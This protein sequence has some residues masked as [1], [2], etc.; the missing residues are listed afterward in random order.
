MTRIQKLAAALP[1]GCGGA[2]I[3]TPVNR[4]YFT[5]FSSSDGVLFVSPKGA[6]F[7][8]DSRYIE[9]ARAASRDPL[10]QGV[11]IEEFTGTKNLL[12]LL[13]SYGAA[14]VLLE[15]EITV[16]TWQSYK[17]AL[18]GVEVIASSELSS[19]ISGMRCIKEAG[20]IERMA[21]AAAIADLAFEHALSFLREGLTE[22]ALA[23]ELEFFMRKNGAEDVSFD[24]ITI[25]GAK[26]SM[27][28]GA[29]DQSVIRRG[30]FITMDIGAKFEGYCSDMTRTVALGSVSDEMKRVY[31]TV[32]QVQA[33]G[34]ALLKPGVSCA[35]VHEQVAG[36][37]DLAGYGGCFR[38]ATGHSVGLEIHESP[39]LSPRETMS[40]A[41]GMVVTME[42]GI[43]LEG[44]F[45][46][47]I[48][49]M[50]VITEQG[51]SNFCFSDK[52]LII[53]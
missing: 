7:L 45:G 2:L 29:P 22:H 11:E 42:P 38:H 32:R 16:E 31:E 4:R 10:M 40:L 14:R 37:I 33:E 47:R 18:P 44:R 30:D 41:P 46:V 43:Y 25:S 20:E 6:V 17:R 27:P 36:R 15:S 21:R 19:I 5:G 49:D 51:F 53:L 1:G 52:N 23:L 48:E 39:S 3:L 34:L 9:A 26:T 8:T 24:L 12:K 50:V 28:H 13:R 35:S